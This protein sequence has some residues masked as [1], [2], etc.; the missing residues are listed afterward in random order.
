MLLGLVS[1][2]VRSPRPCGDQTDVRQNPALRLAPMRPGARPTQPSKRPQ[3]LCLSTRAENLGASS[4]APE[5]H[6][7]ARDSLSDVSTHPSA[8]EIDCQDE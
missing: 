3:A 8:R 6:D 1:G 5:S 4:G 2:K 7:R